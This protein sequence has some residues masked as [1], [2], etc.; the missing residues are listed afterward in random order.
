MNS[1]E[2]RKSTPFGDE[3]ELTLP[4]NTGIR[5][6]A[7]PI[8][9]QGSRY[10]G[11]VRARMNKPFFRFRRRPRS[12]TRGCI[13]SCTSTYVAGWAGRDTGPPL[14]L[15]IRVNGRPIGEVTPWLPRPD[16]TAATGLDYAFGFFFSFP[17]RLADGDRVEVLNERRAHLGGSPKIYR[18]VPLPTDL[19]FVETRASIAAMFLRGAGLEIGAFTQPTDLPSDATIEY[20]DKFPARIVRQFYD[21]TCGRPLVEPTYYGNAQFLD[22]IAP[23]KTFDF[24]I[25]NHVIEHFEDPISFLKALPTALNAAGRVMLTAPNKRFTFDQGRDLTPFDH[26]LEDH[27]LGGAQRNRMSHYVEYVARVHGLTGEAAEALTKQLEGD[28][29]SIHFHVWDETTFVNFVT[30]A[31]QSFNLPLALLFAYNAHHEITVI[32]EKI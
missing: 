4:E 21:E 12:I 20:Y 24:I 18:I 32:L 27:A 30:T 22:G 5:S 10:A 25:A 7:R 28:D 15:S 19:G 11:F 23:Q 17:R 3:R 31:I 16:V 29:F 14:S 13:G 6:P 1:S 9:A 26:L 8:D 2:E